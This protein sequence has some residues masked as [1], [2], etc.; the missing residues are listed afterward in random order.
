MLLYPYAVFYRVLSTSRLEPA[1]EAPRGA[2]C[3][4]DR[5][6]FLVVPW[7]TS[8]GVRLGFLY[9][10]LSNRS[11]QEHLTSCNFRQTLE[12]I[13]SLNPPWEFFD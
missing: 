10:T 2:Y 11:D 8:R 5:L 13:D 1:S 3:V 4:A 9:K 7:F 6:V 12:L